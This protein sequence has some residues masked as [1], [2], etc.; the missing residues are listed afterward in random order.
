MLFLTWFDYLNPN[1]MPV[2]PQSNYGRYAVTQFIG[3]VKTRTG[4]NLI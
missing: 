2:Y 4:K 1:S 3:S